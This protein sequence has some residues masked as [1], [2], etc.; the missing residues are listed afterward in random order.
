MKTVKG[1]TVGFLVAFVI[2]LAGVAI[3]DLVG[4]ITFGRDGDKLHPAMSFLSEPGLGFYRSG[5]D[6]LELVGGNLKINGNITVTGSSTVSGTGI[7]GGVAE[8]LRIAPI[9][10]DGATPTIASTDCGK[11]IISTKASA[12]QT[13]TLPSAATV[14]GCVYT[15]ITG[16]ADGEVLITPAASQDINIMT[17]AAVGADADTARVNPA[18]GTG[19]KNTAASNV[20]GD[21]VVLLSNGTATWFGIG[22]TAGIWASQ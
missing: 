14:P 16:H 18:A 5:A 12:T 20:V 13:Y 7:T 17:W 4:N 11:A 3:A 6:T 1:F 8:N 19:I 9:V 15:F 10:T 22:I 2:G 21:T